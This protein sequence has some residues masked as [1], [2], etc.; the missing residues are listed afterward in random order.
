MK[1]IKQDKTHRK[2]KE[3]E[4]MVAEVIP[5]TDDTTTLRLF[6][7]DDSLEY[8]PGH[9]IT[10]DPHQFPGIQRWTHYLE[11]L[12]GKKEPPRA[13]SLA[14]APHEKYLSI[15]VKEEAYES[16]VTPY[17]PLLSPI[18]AKRAPRGTSMLITGFTGP[19]TL[20]D[21]LKKTTDTILHTCAGSGVV[22]SYSIIK[23]SLHDDE[24]LRHV[25]LLSNKTAKDVIF[26]RKLQR[27]M[28]A[29]PDRFE[30][31]HFLTREEPPV[32]FAP[33]AVRGRIGPEQLKP[34]LNGIE[35]P[36]CFICGPGLTKIEKQRAKAKGKTP[37]PRFMESILAAFDGLGVPANRIQREGWG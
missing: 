12:K 36:L 30:V 26:H 2:V 9:F 16:G 11:D 18:L 32:G 24:T 8:K 31:H 21:D 20:S 1:Q 34:I 28:E 17:P 22:P 29:Y 13:Y 15:T 7:G 3:L 14:S 19:Y 10:I 4:V 25:L 37:P 5:E 27:L 33:N 23:A 6:T 35:N